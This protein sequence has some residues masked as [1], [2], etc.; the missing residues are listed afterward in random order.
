MKTLLTPLGYAKMRAELL[1]LKSL[2]PELARAIEVARAHGDLSENADYDAAK[3]RSGMT[4]ARIRDLEAKL[5]T[6]EVVDP[7]KQLSSAGGGEKVV[8]G[9]ETLIEDLDSG[10]QK[11]ITLVGVD[12]SDTSIGHLSYQS[13]FGKA[14]I[15][16][17]VSDVAKV[18]APG[19]AR[20]YEIL[21]VTLVDW[22]AQVAEFNANQV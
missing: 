8:F 6:A 17:S 11:R 15:G 14:L 4:E 20:E 13:P 9:V 10:E 21:E 12:E 22:D 5:A 16:R 3:E 7:K 18:M 19:G 2:R 1:R